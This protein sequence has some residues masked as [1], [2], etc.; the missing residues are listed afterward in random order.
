LSFLRNVVSRLWTEL[1]PAALKDEL[2]NLTDDFICSYCLGRAMPNGLMQTCSASDTFARALQYSLVLAMTLKMSYEMSRSDRWQFILEYPDAPTRIAQ[3][4]AQKDQRRRQA[5]SKAKAIDPKGYKQEKVDEEFEVNEGNLPLDYESDMEELD[6]EDQER[7][8]Q[9][10]LKEEEEERK[11][12]MAEKEED[13]R[14]AA[15][16]AQ[17]E[18]MEQMEKEREE[19]R[20]KAE[21]MERAKKKALGQAGKPGGE[22]KTEAELEAEAEQAEK[23]AEEL[24]KQLEQEAA[25]RLT[26]EKEIFQT[27]VDT[28]IM[29]LITDVVEILTQETLYKENIERQVAQATMLELSDE[30]RL[31][32]AKL[33]M[34]RLTKERLVKRREIGKVVTMLFD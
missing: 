27:S 24:E 15:E 11:E 2:A 5:H 32:E 29:S 22:N 28:V 26:M 18:L 12:R 1:L 30:E 4:M 21:A 16:E 13:D 20:E 7:L 8:R 14:I 10:T 23:E 3:L 9:E 31:A 19:A 6:K 34:T 33:Q 17:Y 25:K